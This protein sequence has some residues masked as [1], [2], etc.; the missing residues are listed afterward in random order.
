MFSL[1]SVLCADIHRVKGFHSIKTR[2]EKSIEN[3]NRTAPITKQKLFV[4]CT[5]CTA[6]GFCFMDPHLIDFAFYIHEL[7]YSKTCVQISV[8]IMYRPAF[9]MM[10]NDFLFVETVQGGCV[11]IRQEG[12]SSIEMFNLH[13]Q[14]DV[15]QQNSPLMIHIVFFHKGG[16]I[17]LLYRYIYPL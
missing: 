2:E 5:K 4:L 7:F 15:E 14:K 12:N 3:Q 16:A 10:S 17:A 9:D 11:S 13:F 8:W 6:I 1:K